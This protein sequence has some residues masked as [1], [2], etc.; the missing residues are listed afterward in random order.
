MSVQVAT[1]EKARPPNLCHFVSK[2]RFQT[3]F[4][5]TRFTEL[6][7]KSHLRLYVAEATWVPL[8][9]PLPVSEGGVR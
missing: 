3:Y 6:S 2:I 7:Y 4:V 9:A 5:S 8:P 1:F